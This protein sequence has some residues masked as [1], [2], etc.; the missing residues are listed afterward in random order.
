MLAISL[1]KMQVT[2]STK[3]RANARSDSQKVTYDHLTVLVHR[4]D[5]HRLQNKSP[6]PYLRT[7]SFQLIR[8]LGAT[9]QEVQS[10]CRLQLD[11]GC[12]L[13]LAVLHM[14]INSVQLPKGSDRRPGMPSRIHTQR[15]PDRDQTVI[16]L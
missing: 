5:S 9:P 12:Y 4:H 2:Q 8:S 7:P 11:V 16:N 6:V 3:E 14:E 1:V 13:W 10:N 15:L